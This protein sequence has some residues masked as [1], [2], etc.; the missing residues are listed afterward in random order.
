MTSQSR[1]TRFPAPVDPA[2]DI[3]APLPDAFP[4]C[5]TLS[6]CGLTLFPPPPDAFSRRLTLSGRGLT[7][8]PQ[9]VDDFACPLTLLPC[10]L[11]LFGPI[12]RG[13]VSDM[14]TPWSRRSPPGRP[15]QLPCFQPA[16]H[17][18]QP[19]QRGIFGW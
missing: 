2:Y 10:K 1:I 7:L 17:S 15:G 14:S 5:L 8:L 19:A 6:R 9:P 4:R 12:G 11:T 3:S 18:I 16:P 13:T